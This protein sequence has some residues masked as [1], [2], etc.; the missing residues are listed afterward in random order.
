VTSQKTTVTVFRTS[1]WPG[2]VRG[3]EH[4]GQNAKS[5]GDSRPQF[6][7]VSTGR[8]YATCL[9]RTSGPDSSWSCF[10]DPRA[11]TAS[12]ELNPVDEFLWL[13]ASGTVAAIR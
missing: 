2:A 12:N 11:K 6:A 13:P 4:A 7:Q 5:S 1:W 10:D 9:L 8:A 3:A